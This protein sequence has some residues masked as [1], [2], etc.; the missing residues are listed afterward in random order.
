MFT[1]YKSLD[2]NRMR[3]FYEYEMQQLENFKKKFER[4]YSNVLKS[5]GWNYLIHVYRWI[6]TKDK[7][8]NRQYD[9]YTATLQIDFIDH[10]NS[11]IELDESF[12]SCFENITYI[13]FDLISRRYSVFQNEEFGELWL[14][15][16]KIVNK[17]NF[18]E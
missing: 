4:L 2:K 9:G 6:D 15:V 3:V 13:S 7:L 5:Y 1:Y 8:S 11:V 18:S 17:L 14:G 12:C 10:N 16:K